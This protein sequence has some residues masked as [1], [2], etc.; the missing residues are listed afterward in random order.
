VASVTLAGLALC[1]RSLVVETVDA[2]FL[3]SVSRS[4]GPTQII[5]LGL[6]VLNLVGGFHALGTL[7]AV[8]VMMLPAAAARLWARDISAMLGLAAVQGMAASYVGLVISYH[9][10]VPSG[11]MII[12]IA[13]LFYLIA[14]VF[15]SAGGLLSRLPPRRHLR[16]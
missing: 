5:F 13:G 11:P 4:G 6:V 7:L 10:S 1:Y 15:G 16:A 8:G 9:A 14:L 2:G 12:L 3:A